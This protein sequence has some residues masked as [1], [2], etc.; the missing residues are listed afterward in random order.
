MPELPG[1][2]QTTCVSRY[3]MLFGQLEMSLSGFPL[4]HIAPRCFCCEMLE[5][6]IS[7][8]QSRPYGMS[9]EFEIHLGAKPLFSARLRHFGVCPACPVRRSVRRVRPGSCPYLASASISP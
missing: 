5:S 1:L 8:L 4:H 3:L 7:G 9:R 6:N 2:V